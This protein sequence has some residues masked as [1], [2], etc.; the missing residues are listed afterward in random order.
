MRTTFVTTSIRPFKKI[1]IVKPDDT[2]AFETICI[3][4]AGEIDQICNLIIPLDPFFYLD[5]TKEFVMRYD[6]DILFNLT[7]ESDAELEERFQVKTVRPDSDN[8]KMAK[9]G[10]PLMEFSAIPIWS[11][12]FGATFSTSVY[13]TNQLLNTPESLLHSVNFGY[14]SDV[15]E[16]YL[17]DTIF[18]DISI[19]D[20]TEI[21]DLGESIFDHEKKFCHLTTHIGF[22]EGG[23]SSVWEI[24][25]NRDC[26][27][28]KGIS[29][30]IGS[31]SN[32]PFLYYFWN[33]RAYNPRSN[34]VWI[35]TELLNNL[36]DAISAQ[37]NVRFYVG[38]N[39]AK[40]LI[41]ELFEGSSVVIVERYYFSGAKTRWQCFDHSQTAQISGDICYV[42]HPVEK[43]FFG[44][45]IGT[46]VIEVQGIS[47][48][49][50]PV[51]ATFWELYHPKTRDCQIFQDRFKRIGRRG[52]AACSINLS[53]DN[54]PIWVE[55]P[56]PSFWQ[57][58]SHLF[59]SKNIE[60]RETP[61]SRLL[62][63]LVNLIGGLE[64]ADEIC[65]K[66]IFDLL[67]SS[68]PTVRTEASIKKLFPNQ[69]ADDH[70]SRVE[71][72][73]RAVEDGTVE[74]A[75]VFATADDLFTKAKETN[76][77]LKKPD[78]LATL[79]TIYDRRVFLR[80]KHFDCPMCA[81]KV[82]FPLERLSSF[83]YCHD[84][85]NL[86]NL[87]VHINGTTADKDKYRLNQLLVRA[88]DQ[89]QLSTLLLLNLLKKQA[90]RV[91]DYATNVEM[92]RGENVFSDADILF[93]I[94]K[95]L[96]IAECKSSRNFSEEQVDSMIEVVKQ[97]N[98]DFGIFSC[99]LSASCPELAESVKYIRSKNLDFPIL[100]ITQEVLFSSEKVK[101]YRYLEV[102]ITEKFR[103][104]PVV[105]K[106]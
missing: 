66:H 17:Q 31:S 39:S 30:F 10:T 3:A 90:F 92:L 14:V 56:L 25:Y 82:W 34:L 64:N 7:D 13:A 96:G 63:Q 19:N 43:T 67:C 83:N 15:E 33:S 100:I 99:L 60:I 104:G 88:I 84:C 36:R 42:Q 45:G 37:E 49:L 46:F 12:R 85:G 27:F 103:T 69:K 47:E 41:E 68:S 54:S 29:I 58:M 9:F 55:F 77:S 22:G 79:Q 76:T 97:L 72:V 23:G 86:I 59:T 87:P 24:D 95:K 8:W 94:G 20:T 70:E 35:P 78:F 21:Q 51:R 91:F 71:T 65:Q 81:S 57:V 74:V 28:Q 18:N 102:L 38:D 106:I 48:C 89:G 52:L 1:F 50:Y 61:K 73:S 75:A 26:Y 2:T 32:L 16:L 98:F 80:G 93:R 53:F 44:I 5:S 101:L 11:G 4:L 6:P 40:N 105:I 62:L